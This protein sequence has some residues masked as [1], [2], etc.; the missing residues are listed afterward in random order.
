MGRSLAPK[1]ICQARSLERTC[2]GSAHGKEVGYS[3]ELPGPEGEGLGGGLVTWL[4]Q[5]E[6]ALGRGCGLAQVRRD[7]GTEHASKEQASAEP[8]VE[9]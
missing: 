8:L 4:G 3:D 5:Q 2:R 7:P 1:S 9:Q 6:P